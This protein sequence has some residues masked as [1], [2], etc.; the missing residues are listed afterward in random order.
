MWEEVS[1]SRQEIRWARDDIL[2]VL[3]IIAESHVDRDINDFV[4]PLKWT[5]HSESR[6]LVEREGER[7]FSPEVERR[8]RISPP[9]CRLDLRDQRVGW[10]AQEVGERELPQHRP[11]L[12]RTLEV[13]E[14]LHIRA[15]QQQMLVCRRPHCG[16][17]IA[18]VTRSDL[19]TRRRTLSRPLAAERI[20]NSGDES[21]LERRVKHYIA[22]V[23]L[24][25][26]V[27]VQLFLCHRHA[28]QL[29]G[30]VFH[31]FNSV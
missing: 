12:A 2:D 29:R 23:D 25:P 16:G 5:L 10:V 6:A 4:G 1:C 30:R 28:V 18:Y 9:D 3:V 14:A 20:R 15:H 13:A 22:L 11:P 7:R 8:T 21:L 31:T 26:L 17:P 27:R 24:V 19:Q